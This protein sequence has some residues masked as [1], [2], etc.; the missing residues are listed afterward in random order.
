MRRGF[1]L[2]VTIGIIG[3][4]FWLAQAYL[5]SGNW[6]QPPSTLAAPTISSPTIAAHN[7]AG[8]SGGTSGTVSPA[9]SPPASPGV[10]EPVPIADAAEK[11]RPAVAFIAVRQV[12]VGLFL[13][14]VPQSGVGSGMIFDDAGHI[15]TNNHVVEDAR[16]IRVTL[17]DGRTFPAKLVG[18]DRR[19]DLAVIK[20]DG[21]S[22]PKVRL[23]DSEKLRIG[24]WVVAIGNALGLQGGP[25]VTAG[26]VGALNR[27]ITEPN[28]ENLENLIQTDAAINPGNSGG[29]L[30]NL[31][32][33]V[34]GI[35]TAIASEAQGIGFAISISAARPIIG[36]LVAYGRVIRPFLGIQTA[37]VTPSLATRYDLAV[38]EGLLVLAVERGTPASRAGLQQG[39]VVTAIEGERLHNT[40]E[41]RAILDR[42][43]PGDTLRLT[44]VRSGK[45]STVAVTLAESPR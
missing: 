28:G 39:D 45:Q 34:V 9:P 40:R 27:S 5:S 32:G 35:N 14:A 3:V 25:T 12:S 37:D 31:S 19:T 13:Q 2:L 24:E 11:V 17:P 20:I 41:L 8:E 36:D 43:K 15:L 6:R 7:T 26:V 44:I 38:K 23:G 1:G 10:V 22:L 30:I 18:T 29:P 16:D 4:L 33:E 42:H 21:S